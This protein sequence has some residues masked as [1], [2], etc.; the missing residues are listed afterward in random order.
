MDKCGDW[1]FFVRR[2]IRQAVGVVMS[3]SDYK[4]LLETY[5]ALT[6]AQHAA[7]LC[8]PQPG[9]DPYLRS[10]LNNQRLALEMLEGLI[11]A[12]AAERQ[13]PAEEECTALVM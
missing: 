9:K 13:P 5:V 11:S 6:L 12:A 7:G 2:T 1:E 10:V 8:A 3:E 4:V